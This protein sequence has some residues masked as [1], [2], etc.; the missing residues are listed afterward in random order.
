MRHTNRSNDGKKKKEEEDDEEEEEEEED[1]MY[2][3]QWY[4][5]TYLHTSR[6]PRSHYR[7]NR[8][9]KHLKFEEDEDDETVS[10]LNGYD[11]RD[12][13][14][15]DM[16]NV[17]EGG[18]RIS[19]NRS[20]MNW[21]KRIRNI[22]FC[23]SVVLGC[24]VV[25]GLIY[26]TTTHRRRIRSNKTNVVETKNVVDVSRTTNP[27]EDMNTNELIEAIM[28]VH[29]WPH[30]EERVVFIDDDCKDRRISALLLN[31]LATLYV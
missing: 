16:L 31:E 4:A 20:R 10:L 27:H 8:I 18:G 25:G 1:L 15:V 11:Q 6:H 28:A 22:V 19:S 5:Q 9:R 29:A 30:A 3:P 17:R 24:F 21:L 23:I 14:R 26:F 2:T 13:T 7:T 12:A